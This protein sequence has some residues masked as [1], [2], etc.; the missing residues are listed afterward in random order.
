MLKKHFHV[1]VSS[2]FSLDCSQNDDSNKTTHSLCTETSF[3]LNF[4]H[5]KVA[6]R[7]Y[8]TALQ[9]MPSQTKL[10]ESTRE[11]RHCA[12]YRTE[13]MTDYSRSS[14]YH[15]YHYQTEEAG[16]LTASGKF[17]KSLEESIE[18]EQSLHVL[19]VSY[20]GGT[21]EEEGVEDVDG[22]RLSLRLKHRQK[23][24]KRMS[25]EWAGFSGG[26]S[27]YE[28]SM[29]RRSE[30]MDGIH[31]SYPTDVKHLAHINPC[32]PF[33]TLKEVVNNT[34]IHPPRKPRK[35]LLNKT[36][37]YRTP[38]APGPLHHN[39]VPPLSTVPFPTILITPSDQQIIAS[40]HKFP[41][42]P[43]PISDFEDLLRQLKLSKEEDR[44]DL[45][46]S[47]EAWQYSFHSAVGNLIHKKLASEPFYS[48]L[49]SFTQSGNEE[50]SEKSNSRTASV[51]IH[52]HGVV[53]L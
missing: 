3:G 30:S 6:E 52:D 13:E 47:T 1:I 20:G 31:I 50:T 46:S 28:P 7:F 33:H 2:S 42:A 8:Q 27:E 9:L 40:L 49:L 44:S 5:E 23:G 45:T 15:S 14:I 4:A 39:S 25:K 53:S 32:T 29:R 21:S 35:G 51:I 16:A 11:S 17:P 36:K 48:K 26:R 22:R 38:S 18:D 10:H 24:K 41:T 19:Q 37:L 12:L 43:P 34:G